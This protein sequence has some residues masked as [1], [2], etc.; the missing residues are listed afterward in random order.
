MEPFHIVYHHNPD[1]YHSFD[2]MEEM[3]VLAATRDYLS[4]ALDKA[5]PDNKFKRMLLY[6]FIREQDNTTTT[7]QKVILPSLPRIPS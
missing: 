3:D 4:S 5:Q 2:G 1:R 6:L 7:T